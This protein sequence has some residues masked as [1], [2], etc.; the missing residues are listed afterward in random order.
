[1]K[2]VKCLLS[3]LIIVT[4]VFSLIPVYAASPEGNTEHTITD[5][6]SAPPDTKI[7]MFDYWTVGG[8][9]D[10]DNDVQIDDMHEVVG[11]GINQNH[12]LLFGNCDGAYS[13]IDENDWCKSTVG[14]W[15]CYTGDA[16]EKP[17][18]LDGPGNPYRG[19]VSEE[20]GEDGY[21]K[22]DLREGHIVGSHDIS[23]PEVYF[24]ET[25]RI[26]T[27]ESLAY[28]FDPNETNQS[29]KA[30]Y[31]NASGLLRKNDNGY[32]YFN[33]DND[34]NGNSCFA[35]LNTENGE[36]KFV[37]YETP[38]LYNYKPQFFP[39]GNHTD[40]V[41]GQDCDVT[42]EKVNH[43][44]GMTMEYEFTQPKDGIV[45][46]DT[47]GD[48]DMTFEISGDDDI[49]V[50]IDN[51][52]A[53]DMGGIHQSCKAEINFKDG[54]INYYNVNG[55]KFRTVYL[56]YAMGERNGALDSGKWKTLKE[57]VTYNGNE[58]SVGTFADNT[59]HTMK[60]FYL[61][62]G[63][64]DS[65]FGIKF[66]TTKS[67]FEEDSDIPQN[68][69]W[70]AD[71]AAVSAALNPALENGQTTAEV[72]ADGAIVGPNLV[73]DGG[74]KP[75][76][77]HTDG[78]SYT[79]NMGLRGGSGSTT[80][81]FISIVPEQGAD[82]TVTVVFDG[83]GGE[84]REQNIVYGDKKETAKSV[85]EGASTVVMDLTKDDLAA[86]P[87]EAIITYGG[88]SNKNVYAIFLEYFVSEPEK[89]VKG[90]ITNSTGY[91]FTGKNIVF[92]NVSDP[93][94]KY[95]TPYG[96][97]YSLSLPKGKTFSA[98][99]EG[100]DDVCTTLATKEITVS[101][102]RYDQTVDIKFVKIEELQVEGNVSMISSHDVLTPV[103]DYDSNVS[104]TLVFT[105][106]EG[107]GSP[108]EATVGPD[109]SYTVKLMSAETYDVS[110][111]DANGYT[112]SPLSKTYT[113]EGG[114]EAP[115]KNILLMKDVEESIAYKDTL[116]VGEGKDYPSISEALAAVRLMK[117]RTDGQVVTIVIDPGEYQEQ[118]Y[119]NVPDIALKAADPNNK[120]KI[121]FYY[122]IGYIYYSVASV[123]GNG[124]YAGWYSADY[125]V[126]KTGR[127]GVKNWGAT[128]RTTAKG[129]YMENIDVQ[130]SYNLYITDQEIADGIIPG[131]GDAKT[132]QRTD[133]NTAV[134]NSTYNERAAAIFAGGSEIEIYKCSFVSSQDTFGTGAASMYVKDCL[135]SGNTDYI[136]GGDNCYFEN[137]E[138]RWQGMT[139]KDNGGYITA[140]KTSAPT[141]LGY[142]FKNCKI[143]KNP[144]STMQAGKGGTWGRPWGGA[145]TPTI[146]DHTIIA[147]NVAKPNGWDSMSN[148]SPADA[149]F[150]VINGVYKE[151]DLET[152]L[153]AAVDNPSDS[154]LTPTP[155]AT[156][157]F[158]GWTPKNYVAE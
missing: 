7:N 25:A 37:L 81:R 56:S 15:N 154:V 128:I 69:I 43:Y 10:S 105:N 86:N 82:L 104:T 18:L 109:G 91:D 123:D 116:T 151:S 139:D 110:I 147:D 39:F 125:A 98:T 21:P 126:Q 136:C 20:L 52:L 113:L 107:E 100:V 48:K 138:L 58:F 1:M 24:D 111:K 134:N 13:G 135:I 32:Y 121:T 78:T 141:D 38:W 75:T 142:Y 14:E 92:T 94:E 130:N 155:T 61:E 122:G 120:P 35:E 124:E 131:G 145:N 102:N 150:S 119:V 83:H 127:Y 137:C 96:Y 51:K 46:T 55:F 95:T 9:N 79:F 157:Y 70:R 103:Y 29:G 89:T 2:K 71:S 42:G 72:E 8:Q 50:F 3:V 153:T 33:S 6:I 99:I 108:V 112:L 97:T 118:L 19:I 87:Q 74:K 106:S 132:V 27:D 133:K 11:G 146:Y 23:I 140:C 16:P 73:Y 30:S 68:K 90:N 64:N 63:N 47:L 54:I 80:N 66:N 31:E 17:V 36:N 143:T 41:N 77:V 65:G 44:F 149:R 85:A 152:D 144:D 45:K 158:G 114:D 28:L 93:S 148:T 12:L 34:N 156:D 67:E 88:G 115:F 57:K 129:F 22:L 40:L 60:V 26:K 117:D 4:M 62:R 84:G 101:K 76:Y 49:W 59:I 53:I 5:N